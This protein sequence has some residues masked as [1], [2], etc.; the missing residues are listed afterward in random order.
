MRID[1]D[2]S[3]FTSAP[4]AE[5]VISGKIELN[6]LPQSGEIVS[7]LASPNGSK[8]PATSEF[9]PLLKVENVIHHVNSQAVTIQLQDVVLPN[10]I[11]VAEVTAFLEQGFGLFFDPA[12]E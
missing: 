1:I 6:A 7:F 10:K 12:G 8:F 9:N 3:I 5:G 11:S 2:F 4:S